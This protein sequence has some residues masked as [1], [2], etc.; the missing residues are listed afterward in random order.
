MTYRAAD[1]N[2]WQTAYAF[3]AVLKTEDALDDQ[4]GSRKEFLDSVAL[5]RVELAA[6]RDNPALAGERET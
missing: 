6:A 4:K 3:D 1:F 5:F 2:G